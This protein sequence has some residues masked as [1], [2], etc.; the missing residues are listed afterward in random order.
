VDFAILG[1][2]WVSRG[3]RAQ[4]KEGKKEGRK[5]EKDSIFNTGTNAH[6]VFLILTSNAEAL[7]TITQRGRDTY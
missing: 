5:E 3:L 7:G 6:L 2:I 4:Q 1:L